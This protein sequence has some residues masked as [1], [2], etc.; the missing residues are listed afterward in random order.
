MHSVVLRPHTPV[1]TEGADSSWNTP[2][3]LS[4]NVDII[5]FIAVNYMYARIAAN[6]YSAIQRFELFGNYVK[7][8]SQWRSQLAEIF[9]RQVFDEN[10]P[11]GFAIVCFISTFCML[12][13][14]YSMV[15]L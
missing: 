14:C 6:P 7:N 4:I 11:R 15:S 3:S 5:I 1:S 9:I 8:F 13:Q 2:T 10:L 12:Q